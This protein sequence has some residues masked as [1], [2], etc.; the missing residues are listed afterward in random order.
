ML[1][2]HTTQITDR[3]DMT[4]ILNLSVRNIFFLIMYPSFTVQTQGIIFSSA[5]DEQKNPSTHTYILNGY[6]ICAILVWKR[7]EILYIQLDN[8]TLHCHLSPLNCVLLNNN[9]TTNNTLTVHN[10]FSQ[11]SHISQFLNILSQ[12]DIQLEIKNISLS[13]YIYIF[14]YI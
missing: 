12:F 7:W 4:L 13:V 3:E 14:V 6:N 1:L 5:V 11:Q 10:D 8:S 2:F 9:S